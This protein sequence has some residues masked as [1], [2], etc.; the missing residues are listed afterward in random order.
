VKRTSEGATL[1]YFA[2]PVTDEL[3]ARVDGSWGGRAYVLG[4]EVGRFRLVR[5]A[6]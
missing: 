3:T 5:E 4:R 1:D 6:T 2:L